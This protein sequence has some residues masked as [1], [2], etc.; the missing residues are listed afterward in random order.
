[1]TN[2]VYKAKYNAA[3][4][5]FSKPNAQVK[6]KTLFDLMMQSYVA[7]KKRYAK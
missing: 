5:L 3:R 6:K 4:I 7:N 2:A 1:M